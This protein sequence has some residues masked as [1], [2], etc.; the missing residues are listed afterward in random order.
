MIETL[1]RPW[2]W[3]E[4]RIGFSTIK[5]VMVHPVPPEVADKKTGWLFIWGNATMVVFLLQVI[6]GSILATV[7]VPSPEHA[8]ESLLYITNDVPL[9]R[10]LRGMHFYGASAMVL[11]IAIHMARVFLTA[12]Y[13]F[14]RELNWLSGVGLLILTLGMAFTG[15]LL[16]WDENGIWTVSVAAYVSNEVPLI[17]PRFAE[18][19]LAGE[20]VGGTTLTRFYAF[21]VFIFPVTIFGFVGMHIYLVLHHGISE[22]PRADQPV[23]P[24]NYRERYEARLKREGRPYWP[25][26]TWREIAVGVTTIAIIALLAFFFGPRGP[27]E[28]PD[29]ANLTANPQPDWFFIWLYALLAFHPPGILGVIVVYGPVAILFLLILLPFVFSRGQRSPM[30]RPWAPI[31]VLVTAG[32]LFSLTLTGL[33]APWVPVYNAQ[34][35]PEIVQTTDGVVQQGALLIQSEGCLNCHAVGGQGG[36]MGPEFETMARRLPPQEI[37]LRIVNGIRQMPA[38]RDMLTREELDAIVSFIVSLETPA[39]EEVETS[40]D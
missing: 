20:T 40:N 26:V 23:D 17:G 30:R 33:Q 1:L 28:P 11:L 2:R 35:P 6:T 34:V 27:N 14:P 15:Q 8:Y 3:L 12:S 9:G 31:T 19:I 25:D 21:H 24:E 22:L 38:Y 5:E 37:T 4:D 29:P 18:F 32:L 13:K 10:L 16:R 7:Y 36:R 39:T